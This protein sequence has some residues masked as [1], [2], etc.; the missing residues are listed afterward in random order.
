MDAS[1]PQHV[2]LSSPGIDYHSDTYGLPV[3][4]ADSQGHIEENLQGNGQKWGEYCNCTV[5]ESFIQ[6]G[7]SHEENRRTQEPWPGGCH[8]VFIMAETRIGM[9]TLYR[10]KNQ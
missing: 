4:S 10:N 7:I 9:I 2:S 5:G 8:L 3:E 6:D 1:S